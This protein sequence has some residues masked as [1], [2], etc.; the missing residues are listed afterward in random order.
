M[1]LLKKGSTSLASGFQ[2]KQRVRSPT[3]SGEDN[4]LKEEEVTDALK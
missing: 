3:A 2:Y 4:K 1:E